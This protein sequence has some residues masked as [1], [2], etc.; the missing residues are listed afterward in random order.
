VAPNVVVNN[1]AIGEWEGLEGSCRG[2][3]QRF[4]TFTV[5]FALLVLKIHADRILCP[6]ALR[7]FCSNAPLP[8]Y[9]T[10]QFALSRFRFNA[11]WLAATANPLFLMGIQWALDLRTQ[12]VPEG[13][14]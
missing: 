12:F 8:I 3:A 1:R 13:W 6:F 14:S 5:A 2:V 9:N 7:P 11:L 4:V 10:S